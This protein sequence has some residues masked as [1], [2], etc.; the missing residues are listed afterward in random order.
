MAINEPE[1]PADPLCDLVRTWRERGV[2]QKGIINGQPV[3]EGTILTSLDPE[4]IIDQIKSTCEEYQLDFRNI[5]NLLNAEISQVEV[6]DNGLNRSFLILG[7][8]TGVTIIKFS[9]EEE[10]ESPGIPITD[11]F[12]E[13]R[14]LGIALSFDKENFAN[15]EQSA[16]LIFTE[17]SPES[18]AREKAEGVLRDAGWHPLNP[19]QPTA[20]SQGV[21]T[22]GEYV[23]TLK[24]R[25]SERGAVS[26]ICTVCQEK[27]KIGLPKP[28]SAQDSS[29]PGS[30]PI[31]RENNRPQFNF[32]R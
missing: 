5:G 11:R 32:G 17:S 10:S 20:A 23:L 15:S 13:L 8:E 16:L 14:S 4:T 21:F 2:Y 1:L 27:G 7:H 19:D 6:S 9:F 29:R 12:P 25:A 18:S 26:V 28:R 22:K 30:G 3:L 24:V 31:I